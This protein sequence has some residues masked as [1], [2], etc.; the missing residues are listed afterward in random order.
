MIVRLYIWQGATGWLAF[1]PLVRP[2]DYRDG[3]FAE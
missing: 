2:V 3:F 1:A